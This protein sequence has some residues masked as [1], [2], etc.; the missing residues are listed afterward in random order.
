MSN[1]R[2]TC[3]KL[4]LRTFIDKQDTG[5]SCVIHLFLAAINMYVCWGIFILNSCYSI[6]TEKSSRAVTWKPSRRAR[7]CQQSDS[8]QLTDL[9]VVNIIFDDNIYYNI[10]RL[11]STGSSQLTNYIQKRLYLS[12]TSVKTEIT[13]NSFILPGDPKSKK[14]RGSLIENV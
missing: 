9:T 2:T 11:E 5:T 14:P 1:P 4:A 3:L 12:T 6:C 13:L 7:I 8:F 10:L